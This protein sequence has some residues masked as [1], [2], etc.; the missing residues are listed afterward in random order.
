M[1]A[2]LHLPSPQI[3]EENMIRTLS[4]PPTLPFFTVYGAVVRHIGRFDNHTL[5]S[6]VFQ[7]GLFKPAKL[8][9][10]RGAAARSPT[11]EP[12]SKHSQTLMKPS[13]NG[14]LP[15]SSIACF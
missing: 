6:L 14:G 11:P 7:K 3:S 13:N 12:Q 15:I 2:Q 10:G 8:R 5:I 9:Y 4:S 1:Y